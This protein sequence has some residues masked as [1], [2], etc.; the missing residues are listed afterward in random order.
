MKEVNIAPNGQ[1]H[2]GKK[3]KTASVLK[4]LTATKFKNHER[5]AFKISTV[6]LKVA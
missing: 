1:K 3:A 6:Y 5:I 2:E 4:R